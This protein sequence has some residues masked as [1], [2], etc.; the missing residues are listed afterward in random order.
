MGSF[1]VQGRRRFVEDEDI[2]ISRQDVGNDQTLALTAGQFGDL[3]LAVRRHV[4][5][6]QGF[7]NG[8]ADF[9][10]CNALVFPN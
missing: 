1:R 8:L 6:F 4:D 9:I 2:R 5:L 3:T 7:R 10:R